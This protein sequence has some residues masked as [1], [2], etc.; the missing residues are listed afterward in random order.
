VN[1]E[2]MAYGFDCRSLTNFQRKS[3]SM[4]KSALQQNISLRH[5]AE[6]D[7]PGWMALL[8]DG[9]SNQKIGIEA[10]IYALSSLF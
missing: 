1:E 10:T 8:Q 7:R 3:T 4:G 9:V 6:T 5:H 2:P